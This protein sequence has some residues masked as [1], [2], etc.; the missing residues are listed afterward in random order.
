MDRA[1]VI[2]KVRAFMV[3][4]VIYVPHWDPCI[5]IVPK[6]YRAFPSKATAARKK[7]LNDLAPKLEELVSTS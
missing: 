1:V 7:Q 3:R 5:K 4:L 6:F 2:G